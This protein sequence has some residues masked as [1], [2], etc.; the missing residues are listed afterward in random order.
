VDFSAILMAR[1]S[2][3]TVR[4]LLMGPAYDDM[5]AAS[6]AAHGILNSLREYRRGRSD[7]P[8]WMGK[9]AGIP[10]GWNGRIQFDRLLE[11]APWV[12]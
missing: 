8:A 7:G 6:G 2:M 12:K 3:R 9:P 11:I 10:A 4:L 1:L 5:P